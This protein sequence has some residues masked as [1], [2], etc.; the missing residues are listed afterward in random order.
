M[1]WLLLAPGEP[2][3][4]K[5]E[6]STT[7]HKSDGDTLHGGEWPSSSEPGSRQ[8][9]DFKQLRFYSGQPCR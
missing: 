4:C 9:A 3:G 1:D 7:R 2:S 6:H 5:R 8:A